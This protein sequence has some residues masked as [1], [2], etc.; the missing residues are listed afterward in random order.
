[1]RV[2]PLYKLT[3]YIILCNHLLS[4]MQSVSALHHTAEGCIRSCVCQEYILQLMPNMDMDIIIW[5]RHM[6]LAENGNS[7]VIGNLASWLAS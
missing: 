2:C 5:E 1:M 6:I 4:M 7:T 3:D